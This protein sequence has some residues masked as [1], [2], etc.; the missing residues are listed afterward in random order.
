M[1]PGLRNACGEQ[2]GLAECVSPRL[3]HRQLI[4]DLEA[5]CFGL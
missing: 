3:H 4:G 5:V 1:L 2:L